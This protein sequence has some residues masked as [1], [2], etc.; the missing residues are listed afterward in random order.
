MGRL[1]DLAADDSGFGVPGCRGA[2]GLLERIADSIRYHRCLQTGSLVAR[3]HV[4]VRCNAVMPRHRLPLAVLVVA[5]LGPPAHASARPAHDAAPQDVV[6]V[7]ARYYARLVPFEVPP[8][9]GPQPALTGRVF[10][11]LGRPVPGATVTVEVSHVQPSVCAVRG[12]RSE[13]IVR[14]HTKADAEGAFS[15]R[16][17]PATCDVSVEVE[18]EGFAPWG[19]AWTIGATPLAVRLLPREDVRRWER[20]LAL[21]D[22]AERLAHVLV[23]T[24]DPA[25]PPDEAPGFEYVGRLLPELRAI[26]DAEAFDRPDGGWLPPRER[27]LRL[28]AAWGDPADAPRVAPWLERT[29]LARPPDPPVRGAT[30]DVVCERFAARSAPRGGPG[31]LRGRSE[32]VSVTRDGHHAAVTCATDP[33]GERET[34]FLL[35]EDEG[36]RL[37]LRGA[38]GILGWVDPE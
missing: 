21:R 7:A 12:P 3:P 15:V 28:L 22:P 20:V 6:D 26:A 34:L 11:V 5:L 17:A 32:R 33:D 25:G 4:F 24:G 30:P 9:T 18:A 37:Q 27:A 35:R 29:P 10:D 36:W 8:A 38:V 31:A 16:F 13:A 14:E 2:A 1:E 23:A 19:A